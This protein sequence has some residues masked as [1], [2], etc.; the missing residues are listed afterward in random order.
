MMGIPI[1][2]DQAKFFQSGIIDLDRPWSAGGAMAEYKRQHYVPKEYLKN[3]SWGEARAQIHLWVLRTGKLVLDADLGKQCY[4]NYFY[5]NDLLVEKEVLKPIDGRGS[6]LIAEMLKRQEG[7]MPYSADHYA[8]VVYTLYQYGRTVAAGDALDEQLDQFIKAALK[9]ADVYDEAVFSSFNAR[10]KNAANQSLQTLAQCVPLAL[11]LKCKLL[12]NKTGV[13]FIT[14]DNPTVFYNQYGES[15]TRGSNTGLA[16]KGLQVFFPVSPTLLV[17]YYDEKVYKVG[18][19]RD[20]FAEVVDVSD[21]RQLNDLQWLNALDTVYFN[22]A[23]DRGEIIRG[24]DRN[25]SRRSPTKSWLTAMAEPETEAGLKPT[26]IQ[27]SKMDHR[28]NLSLACVRPLQTINDQERGQAIAAHRDPDRVQAFKEFRA[29][30]AK[31]QYDPSEW[32]RFIAD[33]LQIERR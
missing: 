19:R 11:D 2:S 24:R 31:G 13:Q 20:R 10:Y 17:I 28:I 33:M 29:L 15:R 12:R 9:A 5:G 14:S 16:T 7:P 25:L 18:N 3:F 26:L 21:V 32:D 22:D 27:S 23:Q 6:G 4:E 30:V 1:I 8:F